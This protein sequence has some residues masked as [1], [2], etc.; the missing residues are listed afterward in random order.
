MNKET[1]RICS[2]SNYVLDRGNQSEENKKATALRREQLI[3]L[4]KVCGYTNVE[5][6]KTTYF[7]NIFVDEYYSIRMHFTDTYLYLLSG[8]QYKNSEIKIQIKVD[9]DLKL[10]KYKDGI[11]ALV[12]LVKKRLK[13]VMIREEKKK[14]NKVIA[15]KFD[16][17][18]LRYLSREF[19]Q[20]A[21]KATIKTYYG[22]DHDGDII[23]TIIHI[24]HWQL[25][26]NMEFTLNRDDKFNIKTIDVSTDLSGALFNQ[27]SDK[28]DYKELVKKKSLEN[29]Y[30]DVCTLVASIVKDSVLITNELVDLF[31]MM[32]YGEK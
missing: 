25:S 22:R 31:L 2:A 27:F 9:T 26:I 23:R 4:F 11:I 8:G 15:K 18:T 13:P 5:I 3:D 20:V 21:Q 14:R 28:V 16:I 10:K 17:K 30:K 1:F 32:I 24:E 7:E 19:P 12:D 6:E 29:H